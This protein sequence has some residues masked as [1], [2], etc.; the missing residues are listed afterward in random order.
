[1]KSELEQYEAAIT[2][3]NEAIRFKP[4]EGIF[5]FTRGLITA[6]LAGEPNKDNI[7]VYKTVIADYDEAIRLEPDFMPAHFS[8]VATN[9]MLGREDAAEAALEQMLQFENPFINIDDI[10]DTED[11][12][13]DICRYYRNYRCKRDRRRGI[14]NSNSIM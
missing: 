14:I 12:D 3:Y 8:R 1:M 13:A 6:T 10:D 9:A 4:E 2:D 7:E 5:Y 11:M